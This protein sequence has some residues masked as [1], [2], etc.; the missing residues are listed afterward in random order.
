MDGFHV[1]AFLLGVLVAVPIALALLAY[2]R[3]SEQTGAGDS[4]GEGAE[5]KRGADTGFPETKRCWEGDDTVASAAERG[6]APRPPADRHAPKSPAAQPDRPQPPPPSTL[7]TL[8]DGGCA[9][10]NVT[11]SSAGKR[12]ANVTA[13]EARDALRALLASEASAGGRAAALLARLERAPSSEGLARRTGSRE[14]DPAAQCHAAKGTLRDAA[15]EE[16]SSTTCASMTLRPESAETCD[17]GSTAIDSLAEKSVDAPLPGAAAAP[18]PPPLP[19]Q[20]PPEPSPTPPLLGMPQG[21]AG[22]SAEDEVAPPP[23]LV[24]EPPA[25]PLA[26]EPLP[27]SLEAVPPPAP[28]LKPALQFG[29][30]CQQLSLQDPPETSMGPT[31]AE[32]E[33]EGMRQTLSTIQRN[34]GR[35]DAQTTGL[36]R[37]LRELRAQ[38]F[39]ETSASRAANGKLNALLADPARVP[40]EQA[41]AMQRL[42]QEV[43][44]LSVHLA[45]SRKRERRWLGI[46]RQ[47]RLYFMQSEHFQQQEDASVLKKHPAGEVF[48]AAAPLPLDEEEL[49]QM[50]PRR[51]QVAQSYCDPYS[52][53]SWPFE[54]NALAARNNHEPQLQEWEE[55]DELSE[56]YDDDDDVGSDPDMPPGYLDADPGDVG[57]DDGDS[58]EGI[59]DA[60]GTPWPGRAPAA[61]GRQDSR[62]LGADVLPPAGAPPDS[63]RSL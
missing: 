55:G 28:V 20:K 33:E 9:V 46:A 26:A 40:A 31:T 38:L 27:A 37:Q 45:D 50:M 32:A 43:S 41:E 11:S 62:G 34:L 18:A 58:L 47:Q 49:M 4:A 39:E 51:D 7:P 35:R 63:A 1:L 8:P 16:D 24:A 36:H 61:D 22:G 19:A 14:C 52:I 53:D 57:I 44:D 42:Q 56:P 17:S 6:E 2:G 48:L 23:P 5:Q 15:A 21:G 3:L 54:P 59:E 60:D 30:T 29:P 10:V 25:P 12:E 13:G